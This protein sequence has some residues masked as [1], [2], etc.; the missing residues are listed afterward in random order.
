MDYI[1]GYWQPLLFW[2]TR[3][4]FEGAKLLVTNLK[5]FGLLQMRRDEIL[6]FCLATRLELPPPMLAHDLARLASSHRVELLP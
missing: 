6:C 4:A 3:E 5:S 2:H 1:L